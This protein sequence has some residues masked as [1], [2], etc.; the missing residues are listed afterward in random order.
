MPGE[1]VL[2]A[3]GAPELTLHSEEEH[4]AL[5]RARRFM[6]T[7]EGKRLYARRAGVEGTM[8][9]AVRRCGL[10]RTRYRGLGKTHLGHLATAAALN[11][12]RAA[13]WLGGRGPAQTRVSRFAQLMTSAPVAS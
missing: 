2:H 3:R 6:Q 8:S 4:R 5:E 9:Q 7:E 12:A 11:I 13:A 1:G 10:R